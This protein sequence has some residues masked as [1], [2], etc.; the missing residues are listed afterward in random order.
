MQRATSSGEC[1]ADICVRMRACPL[2]TTG[3]EKPIT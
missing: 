2:G 3:N 1:A